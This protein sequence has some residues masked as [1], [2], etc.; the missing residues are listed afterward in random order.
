MLVLF[1]PFFLLPRC[2]RT[3]CGIYVILE[4]S[5]ILFNRTRVGT[6]SDVTLCIYTQHFC[7]CQISRSTLL[8][9]WP[10]ICKINIRKWDTL[11]ISKHQEK[12]PFLHHIIC[13]LFL[14]NST[15]HTHTLGK[16]FSVCL[17]FLENFE[18]KVQ[19]KVIYDDNYIPLL[20]HSVTQGIRKVFPKNVNMITK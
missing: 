13:L 6:F 9:F 5:E 20:T 2:I 8:H 10:D 16:C 11:S 1:F 18:L 15:I 4:S 7:F 17:C 3:S 14:I 19:I 12:T